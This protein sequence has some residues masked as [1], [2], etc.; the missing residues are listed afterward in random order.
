MHFIYTIVLVSDAKILKIPLFPLFF[1]SLLGKMVSRIAKRPI[2][3]ELALELDIQ[4]MFQ[5]IS[6]NKVPMLFFE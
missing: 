1:F 3:L 5:S 6:I 2:A 4:R